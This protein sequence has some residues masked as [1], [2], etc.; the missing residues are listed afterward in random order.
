MALIGR[1]E[2]AA[3]YTDGV[4][5]LFQLPTRY[6]PTSTAMFLNGVLYQPQDD[7]GWLELDPL[8]GLVQIKMAPKDLDVLQFF[9]LDA[10]AISSFEQPFFRIVG[11]VR[12]GVKVNGCVK[13][14]TDAV[15]CVDVR[16]GAVA[17]VWVLDLTN[18]R[19]MGVCERAGGCAS[20]DIDTAGCVTFR[21]AAGGAID[22]GT[23]AA[24][25]TAVVT[26]AGGSAGV[27]MR[28]N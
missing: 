15:A 17:C 12:V 28:V 11:C 26:G 5:T 22:V 18:G 4:N 7:D 23:S 27:G 20:V 13:L 2:V 21:D 8:F 19:I 24:E 6:L 10:G 1:F 14:K 3:G 9:Y 25:N 16:T